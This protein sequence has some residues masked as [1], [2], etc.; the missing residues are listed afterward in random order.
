[1]FR[2]FW[3]VRGANVILALRCSHLND[4]LEEHWEERRAYVHVAESHTWV[5]CDQPRTK[6]NG[7]EFIPARHHSLEPSSLLHL[8]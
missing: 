6:G 3:T 5:S 8:S 2:V 1:M 4:E 7:S